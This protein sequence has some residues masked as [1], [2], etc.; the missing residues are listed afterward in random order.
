[1]NKKPLHFSPYKVH[2]ITSRNWRVDNSKMVRELD[3]K[4]MYS[5]EEGLRDALIED[6]FIPKEH[7]ES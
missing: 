5:L 2:E 7:V 6:G 4:P 3:F 1:M